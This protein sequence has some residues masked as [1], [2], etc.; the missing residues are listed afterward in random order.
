MRS[1]YLGNFWWWGSAICV[2]TSPPHDSDISHQSRV[3]YYR[4]CVSPSK[5]HEFPK[6]LQFRPTVFFKDLCKWSRVRIQ[7]E[8]VIQEE[9]DLCNF[10]SLSIFHWPRD[11][12]PSDI[13]W[14]H[15]MYQLHSFSSLF[16]MGPCFIQWPGT[17]KK[18]FKCFL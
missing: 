18:L 17:L 11:L 1:N 10:T 5:H 3:S 14:T 16:P 8:M 4:S 6:L 9:F 2:L 7:E 12:S 15:T 13:Y